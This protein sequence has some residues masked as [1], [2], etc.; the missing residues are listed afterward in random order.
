MIFFSPQRQNKNAVKLNYKTNNNHLSRTK[1]FANIQRNRW[2]HMNSQRK[3]R[4][5]ATGICKILNWVSFE[6]T[7]HFCCHS[8]QTTFNCDFKV[9]H[10]WRMLSVNVDLVR[11]IS[12]YGLVIQIFQKRKQSTGGNTSLIWNWCEREMEPACA[13]ETLSVHSIVHSLSHI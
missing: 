10:W 1:S 12:I 7:R 4:S 8:E 13:M 2:W 6:R 5:N 9:R 11:P 3:K